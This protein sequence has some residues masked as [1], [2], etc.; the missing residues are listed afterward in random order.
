M[1]EEQ[2]YTRLSIF[3]ASKKAP[4]LEEAGAGELAQ[5]AGD[6]RLDLLAAREA[7]ESAR[8]KAFADWIEGGARL[9]QLP[10]GGEEEGGNYEAP[11]GEGDLALLLGELAQLKKEK[12]LLEEELAAAR[13]SKRI[14]INEAGAEFEKAKR[15][16]SRLAAALE[17]REGERVAAANEF[18]RLDRALEE[19]RRSLAEEKAEGER[20][21]KL[22]HLRAQDLAASIKS[23]ADLELALE[24]KEKELAAAR[25]FAKSL[26]GDLARVAACLDERIEKNIL[27][28]GEALK[29][30][31]RAKEIE[32][33]GGELLRESTER[34]AREYAQLA[35]RLDNVREQW[36]AEKDR[37]D[38]LFEEKALLEADL[39]AVGLDSSP[40]R[41]AAALLSYLA[42]EEGALEARLA[43]VR[44]A[45]SF[46]KE[47]S[48]S[49]SSR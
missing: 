2:S 25:T 11:L 13:E 14:A 44:G 4:P 43:R 26:E 30:W 41:A 27:L 39:A 46:L 22:V 47:L 40:Q 35:A 28:E 36:Q 23:E 29:G 9:P 48:A 24:E 5:G 6:N 10:A 3:D 31:A 18:S 17:V 1:S 16:A 38:R 33:A 12:G 19:A 42:S 20:L 32:A 49:L 8:D 37:A 45:R 7:G 21:G 34:A 15:E